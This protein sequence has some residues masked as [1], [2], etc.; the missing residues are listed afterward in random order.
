MT[1]PLLPCLNNDSLRKVFFESKCLLKGL[2][3]CKDVRKVLLKGLLFAHNDLTHLVVK[4]IETLKGFL[5]RSPS[6]PS[7]WILEPEGINLFV[8]ALDL[9]SAKQGRNVV[10]GLRDDGLHTLFRKLNSVT[11]CSNKI[12]DEGAAILGEAIKHLSSLQ[13]LNV[14]NNHIGDAGA[15]SLGEGIKHLSSLQRVYMRRNKIGDAG[16]ASLGV[17]IKQVSSL[18]SLYVSCNKIGYAGAASLGEGI[19]HLSSLKILD[20]SQYL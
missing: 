20:V 19:K 13:S 16:A 6:L 10:L 7:K 12:D 15:A 18:Q 9:R 4:D 8:G 14:S 2:Q 17:G 5:Q 1:L 3:L 11:L